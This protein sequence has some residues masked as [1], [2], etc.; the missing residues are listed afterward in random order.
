MKTY[1]AIERAKSLARENIEDVI[2]FEGT[3]T[4]YL[5]GRERWMG[6]DWFKRLPRW[7]RSE[8]YGWEDCYSE[9][10]KTTVYGGKLLSCHL[11]EGKLYV[12]F[13]QWRNAHPEADACG[14]SNTCC[15]AWESGKVFNHY[16]ADGHATGNVGQTFPFAD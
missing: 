1:E 7:A 11:Y 9:R 8:V 5:D 3:F 16:D 13:N 14:L 4:E 2:T 10:L 6:K 12:S 15:T